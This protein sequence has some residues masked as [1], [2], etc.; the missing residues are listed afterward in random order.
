MKIFLL[1]IALAAFARADSLDAIFA[2]MD[3]ASKEFK[4]VTANLHQ[5]DYLAVIDE[6]TKEDGV[7]HLKRSKNGVMLKVDFAKPNNRTVAMEG[8]M[9]SIFHPEANSVE[10]Y[11]VTKYTSTNTVE[12]LLLLSFG[13][14]SGNELKQ[15]YTVTS[16]GTETIDGKVATKVV[17]VPKSAEMQK[18]ILR[19]T[20]WIPEGQTN[21][22]KERVDKPA[23]NY[24][25]W[26]Y[27][28]VNLKDPVPDSA[29]V[30]KLPRDVHQV[31]AK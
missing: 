21:A 8:H 2:R 24:I 27:S 31:G 30:L 16:G 6:T 29:V 17:L 23:K 19:I 12:Q 1:A 3:K 28:G 25:A 14:A 9:V 20:L 15:S 11:D 13:A 22:L 7:L 5:E 10:R 18:Q 26:T 4:G